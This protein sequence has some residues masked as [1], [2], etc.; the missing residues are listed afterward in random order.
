M[1]S[2]RINCIAGQWCAHGVGILGNLCSHKL[3]GKGSNNHSGIVV[4]C[5]SDWHSNSS[6]FD[7]KMAEEKNLCKSNT[8]FSW[9]ENLI[10]WFVYL[11]SLYLF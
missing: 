4:R 6:C 9:V 8:L 7:S 1:R 11:Y 10:D 2:C 3:V 5:N